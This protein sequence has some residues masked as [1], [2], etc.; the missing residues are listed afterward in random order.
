MSD[1]TVKVSV[2][3][4]SLNVQPY[5]GEC[6][7][8]VINQTLKEIEIICVDAGSTDGTLEI[9]K[10]YEK[11]DSRVKV[12]V[13]DKKSYGYQ[14]NLGFDASKGQYTAILETDDCIKPDMYEYLYN[15]AVKTEAD[16]VK[17]DFESFLETE[18]GREYTYLAQLSDKSA[19]NKVF[20]PIDYPESFSF[21]PSTWSSVYK[22]SFLKDN[23]IRHNETPGA[24]YQDT[25]FW[26]LTLVAA[27]K[28]YFADKAFYMLRRDRDESSVFNKGKIYSVFDEYSFIDQN[29]SDEIKNNENFAKIYWKKKFDHYI[30]HYNRIADDSKIFFLCRMSEEFK[31]SNDK[32][33]I[34][35][36]M[37]Y[38]TRKRDVEDIVNHPRDFYLRYDDEYKRMK[39][40]EKEYQ[41]LRK[42][43]DRIKRDINCL[44]N[45]FSYRIGRVVTFIPRKIKHY[46]KK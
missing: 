5:I 28:V 11:K 6:M 27:E 37:F 13:S 30:Y 20:K 1:N 23:N 24:S 14:V 21:Y 7:E 15:T 36:S 19:Y 18:N 17:T 33:E 9:L 38:D 8:S 4:P 12:I 25:S 2:I 26:F 32:N 44:R 39:I 16:L 10:E 41:K 40:L 43:N 29:I 31:K 3:L 34:D 46:I 22:T 42:E 45:S 35:L